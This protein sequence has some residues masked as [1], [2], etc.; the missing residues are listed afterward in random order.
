MTTQVCEF[1]N[2][3]I[4]ISVQEKKNCTLKTIRVQPSA[5]RAVESIRDH[6]AR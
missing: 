4:N 5:K 6:C 1:M 2:T 3:Q